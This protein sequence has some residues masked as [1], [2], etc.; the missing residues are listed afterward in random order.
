MTSNTTLSLA[1]TICL[2]VAVPA[3]AVESAPEA[4]VE[5]VYVIPLY[6]QMGTDIHPDIY[7][8][9]I[10]DAK[11]VQP[12]LIVFHLKSADIDTNFHIQNDDRREFGLWQNMEMYRD[13]MTELKSELPR[14]AEQI[15]WIEDA[16]GPSTLLALGWSDIYMTEQARLWG[17]NAVQR[18]ADGWQ[19]PDVRAKMY[20]AWVGI[21]SGFA[22]AGGYPL[23]LTW[24]MIEPNRKLGV[25]FEGREVVWQ[26][27]L[28]GTIW[29]V[30]GDPERVTRFES[31][32]AENVMLSKGT[33]VDLQD[34][35]FLRGYREGGYEEQN[36]GKEIV[37]EYIEDWR[38]AFARCE[39]LNKDAR[40]RLAGGTIADLGAAK[41]AKEKIL[42]AARRYPAVAARLQQDYGIDMDGL[43]FEI[44][45]LK[46][47]IAD[48]RRGR[49]SGSS[50]GSKRGRGGGG[51]GGS[52]GGD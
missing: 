7:K 23:E 5:K 19:D 48:N 32:S 14:N 46:K 8:D 47:Q 2:S 51:L 13:M 33:A 50:R 52:L 20:A 12:D 44:E 9:V 18:F 39:S 27:D 3:V 11:E 42:S 31:D 25:T 29:T 21:A 34:L 36:S 49:R 1:S 37:E 10:K 30:D 28:E 4:E 15:M 41:S 24:A 45:T 43:I 35:M 40:D 26:D 38:R 6:G 16:V 17:L 22:E